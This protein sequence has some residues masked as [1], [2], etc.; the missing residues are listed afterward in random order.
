MA[1][2]HKKQ[3]NEDTKKATEREMYVED[4]RRF[5]EKQY[6]DSTYKRV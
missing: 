1:E 3:A 4:Y 2:K 6:Q 5:K